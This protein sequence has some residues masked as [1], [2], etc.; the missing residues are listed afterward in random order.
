LKDN[1]TKI[2]T[3]IV[4]YLKLQVR[5]NLRTR[6]VELRVSVLVLILFIKINFFNFKQT[7]AETTDAGNIQKAADFIR[8]FVLGFEVD[9]SLALIRL[10]DLFLE[11][12]DVTDGIS[13]K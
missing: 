2:L 9:D 3:P 5:Y 1:W 7:C 13:F 4:E 10:D 12:F 11:S 6:C 8:A